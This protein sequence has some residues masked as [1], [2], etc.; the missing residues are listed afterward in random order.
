MPFVCRWYLKQYVIV[1]R[2]AYRRTVWEWDSRPGR[3]IGDCTIDK[4]E[5][6]VRRVVELDVGGVWVPVDSTAHQVAVA[7]EK[8]AGLGLGREGVAAETVRPF[9]SEVTP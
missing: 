4:R 2:R 1:G 6:R 5:W 8:A 7:L 9:S 3:M